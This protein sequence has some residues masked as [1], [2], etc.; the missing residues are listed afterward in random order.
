MR[1]IKCRN[2]SLESDHLISSVLSANICLRTDWLY[3][4]FLCRDYP[5]QESTWTQDI[6]I[7]SKLKSSN[8]ITIPDRPWGFQEVEDPRFQDSRHRRVVRLLALRTGHLYLPEKSLVLISVTP[9]VKPMTIVLPD[10]PWGFQE[11]EVPRFQ[12][13]RLRKVVRLSALRT[14]RFYLPGNIPSTHFCYTLIQAHDHS[15]AG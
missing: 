7:R 14:D 15:A 1:Q 6:L 9:W 5:Q 10:R 3:D 4:C 12:D 13:S 2:N 11:V 8:P